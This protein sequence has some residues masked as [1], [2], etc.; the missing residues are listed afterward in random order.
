MYKIKIFTKP[1]EHGFVNGYTEYY[2]HSPAVFP[3]VTNEPANA[4]VFY[5]KANA[6]TIADAIQTKFGN[7]VHVSVIDA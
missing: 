5:M 1:V 6:L 2:K 7:A 4:D 3:G